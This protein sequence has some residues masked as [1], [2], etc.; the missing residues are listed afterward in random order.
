M[1]HAFTKSIVV[2]E[3]KRL[4][5]FYITIGSLAVLLA[6]AAQA[7]QLPLKTYTIAD[8]LVH[9]SITSIY[10]DHKGFLWFGTFEGLSRFDGYGFVNYDRRDGL[11]HDFINH[12]TEDRQGRL[13]V[14]TN[15]GGVAQLV[16]HSSEQGSAKFVS[17]NLR[18]TND[19]R[20]KN[21]NNVN[22]MVFDARGYLW[23]LTD[24]GLYRAIV[25][26]SQLQFETIIEKNSADS[27]AALE[28]ADG[29]LWFGIADEL[30][31][32]RGTEILHHG[33]IDGA[34][35]STGITGLARHGDGHLLV[36]DDHRVREFV[37]PRA[38]KPR[39][40]WRK[41][42]GLPTRQISPIKT[43]LVDGAGALWLGTGQGLMKYADGK[44]SHYT[45]AN[46]LPSDHV[47]AL[48]TDRV[49]NLW[50]GTA[51]GGC[52]LISEAIISY[53]RS[54]GL[55]TST[56][57]VYE[58]DR[59]RIWGVL[60]D[61]SVAE[62]GGGKIVFRER[63][64]SPIIA[65]P[66]VGLMYS[67]KIWYRWN[68]GSGV[69]IDMPR[70]RLGNGQEIDLAR[71]V[72]TDARLYKD[73]R[74]VLWISKTDRNIYRVDLNGDGDLTV[75]SFP[76]DA[77]F[78]P[79]THMI[80]DGAGGLWLGTVEEIG[81]LRGGRYTL[82]E[83]SEGLPETDPRAFFLDSRGW[84]WV[85]LRYKGVSVTQEPAAD[86]P[87]FLNYS[88]E[89]GHLSSNV[90]RSIAEDRAGRIYFGTDRGL[91]RFDP[92]TNQWTHFTTQDGLAGNFI[93]RV[94][95]DHNGFIWVASEGGI[96]RF[97]PRKEKEANNPSPIYF[98][99]LQVAGE[100]VR[101]AENGVESIAPRELAS[102]QNNL[103]IAFVA[104][105]YQDVNELMYQY[106]LEGVSEKWSAPTLERSVTFGSLAAGK[107]RFLVRAVGEN[108]VTSPQPAVFEFRILP[109][110]YLRW[111]FIAASLLAAGLAIYSLYRARIARLLEMERTRTRIATDLHDDIGANLTRIALLSEVANQQPGNDKVKT[112]LPSI[113]DIARESVASMNDIVWAISPDHNSLVDL[114]RRMRRH[115]EEV[116]AFRDIDLDFTAPTADSDLKLS[117][118]ARHDLLLIFKE[119]VNNA[120][121]H[122]LCT[123]IDIV[124]RCD[125]S[126]LRLKIRD[127]GQGF[128]PEVLNS[129]G[130]GLRSMQRR[131]AALGGALTIQSSAGTTVE[132]AL[133]LR[134]GSASHL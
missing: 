85:G 41:P 75:E 25:E 47:R 8:G 71:Y 99:R 94:L 72:S 13:W 89:Q 78:L 122:S 42:L 134:K 55:P 84:L 120:A 17:L 57:S 130:H 53:T 30:V 126:G 34:S 109:P 95:G 131:A 45:V 10:Q 115:A 102:T 74:G 87:T 50:I 22:R 46:G 29:T 5:G 31:E 114:T 96:S 68:Y 98:S 123:K 19:R 133:P 15:G 64:A 23:C 81:R 82:V 9:G 118:G 111:W 90:V 27:Y 119:A 100:E 83:R 62:I 37:P 125:H 91:D 60:A 93:H 1:L 80:G 51:G 61:G 35:N 77:N 20:V 52:R 70:T 103:T 124:F 49:G 108:G 38:G 101:L 4:A 63:L 129:S 67:N 132:F 24:Y 2:L 107:Y 73:E 104:P 105:T 116:F 58:D 21:A 69:K 16:E 128:N 86:H 110:I 14:A 12:I 92:N 6:V 127:D 121:R 113:A 11:P 3:S 97:D 65:T 33:S 66:S 28:D 44:S 88:H 56:N 32:I 43:L 79:Y 76:T 26:S 39:G 48:A 54:E 59:G 106:Q 7:E 117:V 18:E 40:E 36:A 112:L